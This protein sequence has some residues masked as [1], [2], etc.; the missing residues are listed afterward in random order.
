MIPETVHTSPRMGA[1]IA[2][3]VFVALAVFA[4]ALFM[5]ACLS[6]SEH[7]DCHRQQRHYDAGY[8]V[9]PPPA[10]CDQYLKP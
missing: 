10:W 3:A 5:E 1:F 4:A 9:N 2:N 8:P 7:E 6:A